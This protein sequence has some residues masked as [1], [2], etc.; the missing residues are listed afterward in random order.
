MVVFN[1]CHR[2]G[3]APLYAL[4][5][6]KQLRI[7]GLRRFVCGS[8]GLVYIGLSGGSL[9]LAFAP[10]GVV[11]LLGLGCLGIGLLVFRRGFFN[12]RYRIIK[13]CGFCL[14]HYALHA[15]AG[16]GHFL[17]GAFIIVEHYFELAKFK[18]VFMRQFIYLRL[19]LIHGL[20][21]AV[22]RFLYSGYGVLLFL[23]KVEQLI[24][25]LPCGR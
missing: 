12:L 14:F 7:H 6:R 11:F 10:G 9:L 22:Q 3:I 2:H 20:L 16:F 25:L 19:K 4:I 8:L 18:L 17:R 1:L 23:Q 13:L 5:A 21:A 15:P 24:Q